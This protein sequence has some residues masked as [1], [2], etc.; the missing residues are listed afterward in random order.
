M[1]PRLRR[2]ST[3]GK[4]VPSGST[5]RALRPMV[6]SWGPPARSLQRCRRGASGAGRTAGLGECAQGGG[7]LG[8]R[9]ALGE[10]G[11]AVG[12]GGADAGGDQEVG[13]E[14]G[15]EDAGEGADGAQLGGVGAHERRLADGADAAAW[16]PTRALTVAAQEPVTPVMA[17]WMAGV[18]A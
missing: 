16:R 10:G 5:A 6:Q 2:T 14:A 4:T 1:L 13:L 12:A 18:A 11:A 9:H 3:Q 8:G 7:E 15:A 17:L